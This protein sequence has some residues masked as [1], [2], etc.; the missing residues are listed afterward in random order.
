M[1]STYSKLSQFVHTCY[2]GTTWPPSSWGR[3]GSTRPF[4]HAALCSDRGQGQMLNGEP[5]VVIIWKGLYSEYGLFNSS[6]WLSWVSIWL[7]WVSH[8]FPKPQTSPPS[9]P[10]P[11]E[12]KDTIRTW[13]RKVALLFKQRA[14]WIIKWHWDTA[15]NLITQ[16]KE[17]GGCRKMQREEKCKEWMK[18]SKQ[19]G[20]KVT[21]KFEPD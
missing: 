15:N 4:Q 6:I 16:R 9:S 7:S 13:I 1:L 10:G 19:I 3:V 14:E 12:R 17:R 21:E 11:P 18:W 2:V 5:A 20:H 8:P